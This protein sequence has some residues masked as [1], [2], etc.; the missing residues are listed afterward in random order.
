MSSKLRRLLELDSSVPYK[1]FQE[2]LELFGTS[3]RVKL[4]FSP[5]LRPRWK[6]LT[7]TIIVARIRKFKTMDY[8]VQHINNTTL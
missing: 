8:F 7:V 5:T 6:C 1:Y 2:I 3:K 4:I